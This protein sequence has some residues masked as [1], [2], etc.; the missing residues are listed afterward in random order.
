VQRWYYQDGSGNYF[1]G[2][3]MQY[4]PHYTVNGKPAAFGDT[5]GTTTSAWNFYTPNATP[6]RI[7]IYNTTFSIYSIIEN[8]AN[9]SGGY[10]I[11]VD[12]GAGIHTSSYPG[13]AGLSS[14]NALTLIRGG[15]GLLSASLTIS[16]NTAWK[17][18][19]AVYKSGV[20]DSYVN[21]VR[22][23]S[24]VI[25]F[26]GG[27]SPPI[28]IGPRYTGETLFAYTEIIAYKVALTD[29]EIRNIQQNQIL[30]NEH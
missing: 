27:G 17:A 23:V 13:I 24:A 22:S 25:T 2:G 19:A 28:T 6:I 10:Y 8:H 11:G 9:A 7:D 12:S 18:V 15:N 30:R 4:V 14:S 29:M 20:V 26:T 21:G 1:T 16:G 5:T 3:K